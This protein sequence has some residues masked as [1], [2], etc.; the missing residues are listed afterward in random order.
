MNLFSIN[1]RGRLSCG[2]EEYL[3]DIHYLEDIFLTKVQQLNYVLKE[4]LMNR[5]LIPIYVF[6]LLKKENKVKKCEYLHFFNENLL[7]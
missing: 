1:N 2:L 3:D 7:G 6:S 4:Q 5:L